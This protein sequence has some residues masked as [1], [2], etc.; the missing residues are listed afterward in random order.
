MLQPRNVKTEYYVYSS[1]QR[2]KSAHYVAENG[3]AEAAMHALER[4]TGSIVHLV[5][6]VN[7]ETVHSEDPA[8]EEL[9]AHLPQKKRERP[10][11]TRR[12]PRDYTNF[13]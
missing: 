12:L 4:C 5:K 6:Q 2:H 9:L 7:K 8:S 10:L 11:T 13:Y 1:S 3:V